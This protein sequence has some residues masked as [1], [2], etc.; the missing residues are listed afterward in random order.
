MELDK[1]FSGI[2]SFSKSYNSIKGTV[3]SSQPAGQRAIKKL[4]C[5][6]DTLL[7]MVKNDLATDISVQVSKGQS[8]L[9]RVLWVAFLPRGHRVSTHVSVAVCFGR[10]G[11][12]AVLGIMEPAGISYQVA[13]LV[14]RTENGNL[15]VDVDGPTQGTKYNNRFINP[16]EILADKFDK[17]AFLSH[18]KNS[19]E[20]LVDLNQKRL[21]N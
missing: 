12:G 10:R 14:K 8:T 6:A 15:Q 18:L 3:R 17:E 16:K 7:E 1:Q 21:M 2:C 11:E 13:P 4:N 20:L 5:F 19:V 9:P